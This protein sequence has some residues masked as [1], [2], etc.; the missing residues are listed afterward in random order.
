MKQI[1]IIISSDFNSFWEIL[2]CFWNNSDLICYQAHAL[3]ALKIFYFRQHSKFSIV[4]YKFERCKGRCYWWYCM[5]LYCMIWYFML[6]ILHAIASFA[7]S[8]G[9]C[10]ARCLFPLF[11]LLPSLELFNLCSSL[12]LVDTY[13]IAELIRLSI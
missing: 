5:V 8:R 10:L 4:P 11:N 7:S 6:S 2:S 9:L 3:R 1:Y 13:V 12:S